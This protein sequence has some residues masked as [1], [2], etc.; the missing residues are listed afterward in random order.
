MV[1]ESSRGSISDF[2]VLKKAAV[3]VKYFECFRFMLTMFRWERT[4]REVVSAA[5]V[6][7]NGNMSVEILEADSS[8]RANQLVDLTQVDNMRINSVLLRPLSSP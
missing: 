5:S 7:L 6:Y 2:N 3:P 8:R 1:S 4:L